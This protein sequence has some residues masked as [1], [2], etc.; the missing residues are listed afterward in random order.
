MSSA[1][2]KV[3][4]RA[5]RASSEPPVGPN[6]RRLRRKRGLSLEKLA[7]LSGV[8]RAML[9]Q[10]ELEQSAPTI[11]TVWKIAT[12]LEVP[13]S[14]LLAG[15][16]ASGA[17]F[18]PASSTRVLSSQSGAFRSRA[19]FPVDSVRSVEFYEL[20]LAPKSEERAHA[21]APGSKENLV[22]VEGTLVVELPRVLHTLA[23]RDAI[24]FESDVPHTYRNDGDVP[25]LAYLVMTYTSDRVG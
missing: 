18:V 15:G 13:F 20:T 5:A 4:E 10:I 21:H 25:V 1:E 3:E 23:A 22:V 7:A 24:L 16:H 17:S 12:A 6:L 2:D 11:T 19:L 9:S 8:S 14:A